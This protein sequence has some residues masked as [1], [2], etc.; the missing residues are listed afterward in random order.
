MISLQILLIDFINL[1]KGL[2]GDTVNTASRMEST[3]E[4][5]TVLSVILKFET[6]NRISNEITSNLFK[7]LTFLPALKIHISNVTYEI[8]ETFGTFDIV[9][10]GEIDV[11]VSVFQCLGA[12]RGVFGNFQAEGYTKIGDSIKYIKFA[13]LN[14]AK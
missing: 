11:K 1:L 3:G 8:L 9:E 6:Y 10:R 13:N 12:P 14:L 7:P 2:F 4:G 5:K